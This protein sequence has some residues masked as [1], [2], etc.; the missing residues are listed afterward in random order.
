MQGERSAWQEEVSAGH[1][2][3]PVKALMVEIGYLSETKYEKKYDKMAQH[4]KLLNTLSIA[5]FAA[6]ILPM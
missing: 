1:Q 6:N 5:V 4:G 3:R 2:A